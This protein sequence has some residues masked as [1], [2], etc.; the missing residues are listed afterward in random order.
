MAVVAMVVKR[1]RLVA[2]RVT[3]KEARVAM[4][5]VAVGVVVGAMV[6]SSRE[7]TA[8]VVSNK[9]AGVVGSN[10]SLVVS[11]NSSLVVSNSSGGSK[12]SN[13]GVSSSGL[14]NNMDR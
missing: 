10:N 4:E 1:A 5:E 13:S 9:V 6:A 2:V 8:R 7:V 14:N 12:D 11:S 3:I